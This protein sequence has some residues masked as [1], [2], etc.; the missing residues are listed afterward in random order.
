LLY[1]VTDAE[2]GRQIS[3]WLGSTEKDFTRNEL[4]KARAWHQAMELELMLAWQKH[5]EES[6]DILPWDLK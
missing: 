6:E 2:S 5:N 4:I 3:S 1:S